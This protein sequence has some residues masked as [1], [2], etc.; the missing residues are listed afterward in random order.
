MLYSKS[1]VYVKE[2]QSDIWT[3]LQKKCCFIHS[4]CLFTNQR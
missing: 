2:A 4:S 1:K 3:F